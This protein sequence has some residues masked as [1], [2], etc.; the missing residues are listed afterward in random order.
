LVELLP[1]HD[2]KYPLWIDCIIKTPTKNES[3][4]YCPHMYQQVE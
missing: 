2:E 1:L 3:N 4:L